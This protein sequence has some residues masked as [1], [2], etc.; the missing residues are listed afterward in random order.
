MRVQFLFLLLLLGTSAKPLYCYLPH[1]YLVSKKNA[2]GHGPR[3]YY[4]EK[5]SMGADQ[6]SQRAEMSEK[7]QDLDIL[8]LGR[9]VLLL[10]RDILL[11]GRDVGGG[12]V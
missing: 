3:D 4:K 6:G 8:L 7:L 12:G 9:D 1:S 5:A 11:L 2:G 10:G